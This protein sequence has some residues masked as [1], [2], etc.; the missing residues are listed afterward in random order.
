VELV[1]TRDFKT[2]ERS[3]NAPFI[4]PSPADGTVSPFAGVCSHTQQHS[5]TFAVLF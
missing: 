2:W 4:Q 5:V 3:P 1:R